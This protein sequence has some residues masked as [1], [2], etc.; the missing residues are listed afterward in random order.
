M[1][2]VNSLIYF[3]ASSLLSQC[4]PQ[5]GLADED[6]VAG[7][8]AGELGSGLAGGGVEQLQPNGLT[9]EVAAAAR[10]ASRAEARL[11]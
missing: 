7:N 3:L 6:I 4:L 8:D 1:M 10:L 2:A 9:L 11:S 5:F